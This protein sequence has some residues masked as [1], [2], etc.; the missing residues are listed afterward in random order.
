MC[1][2]ASCLLKFKGHHISN[3][4]AAGHSTA[5]LTLPECDRH[6]RNQVLV[7]N[8]TLDMRAIRR[9]PCKNP[10]M[11]TDSGA[12]VTYTTELQCL[13]GPDDPFSGR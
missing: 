7:I 10:A 2:I 4:V 9:Y 3:G 1:L 8:R 6:R 5:K 12:H 13:R 11:M